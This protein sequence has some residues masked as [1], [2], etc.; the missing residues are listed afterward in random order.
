MKTRMSARHARAGRTPLA[1]KRTPPKQ[2]PSRIVREAL[3]DRILNPSLKSVTALIGP[4]GHG[5]TSLLVQLEER[6]R[7]DGMH[8]AW[9]SLE[10]IDNDLTQLL[11]QFQE[12]LA[13][14]ESDAMAQNTLAIPFDEQPST[15]RVDWIMSRLLALTRPVAVF[16]DDLHVIDNDV[17]LQFFRSLVLG[18]EEPVHFFFASRNNL[19]V[20]FTQQAVADRGLI[21]HTDDLLFSRTESRAFLRRASGV[22][23]S[24]DEEE[25]IFGVT[26]GWPAATQL[27]RLVL[28][29]PQGRTL[30]SRGSLGQPRELADYLAEN[31]LSQQSA[32]VQDFLIRSSLLARLSG[33]LCDDVLGRTDSKAMLAALERS[34]LFVHRLE[35]DD[36]WYGYHSLFSTFLQEHISVRRDIDAKCIHARAGEWFRRA[37]LYEPAMHHFC[38]AGDYRRATET[39]GVWLED[40]VPNGKAST[41]ARWA[42]RIPVQELRRDPDVCIKISWGIVFLSAHQH[43]WHGLLDPRPVDGRPH[44]RRRIFECGMSVR[45]DRLREGVAIIDGVDLAALENGRMG[46]FDRSA[47]IGMRGYHAM[48]RGDFAAADAYLAQSY[49]LA[50]MGNSKLLCAYVTAMQAV[51][52]VATAQLPAAHLHVSMLL[53]ATRMEV[54]SSVAEHAVICVLL[55]IMYESN[56]IDGVIAEFER[57]R[58]LILRAAVHDYLIVSFRAAARTYAARNRIEQMLETLRDAESSA[59]KLECPRA[60]ANLRWERVRHELLSGR[61][62]QARTLQSEIVDSVDP[63]PAWVRFSEENEGPVIGRFRFLIHTGLAAVALAEIETHLAIAQ[64]FGR[65]ARQIKLLILASAAACK[66]ADEHRALRALGEA[67]ALA[68]PGCCLRTFLDEGAMAHDLLRHY[69]RHVTERRIQ[70]EPHISLF[71]QRLLHAL[72]RESESASGSPIQPGNAKNPARSP[73]LDAFTQR[74]RRVLSMLCDYKSND[75]IAQAMFVTRDAVKYHLKNIYEKL[76]VHSRLEAIRVAR[77]RDSPEEVVNQ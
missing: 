77:H 39:F 56:D 63:D 69:S 10:A 11:H 1:Y 26:R 50:K 34:G 62:E 38:E 40:L 16:F 8:T 5:K 68:A 47:A 13:D 35:S 60:I 33:D 67:L 17:V 58:E 18:L 36:C 25:T 28:L 22:T 6:C 21:V 31:V 66:L 65:V 73:G 37:G 64:Q 51:K 54:G 24:T 15:S 30:L 12:L 14:L 4:A 53:A 48:T 74:E 72:D 76:G 44:D 2:Q 59:L 42:H 41:V 45:R 27:Y 61:I 43:R 29:T 3:L 20:G 49:T 70:V 32:D 55:L 46:F 57:N 75:Q 71:L 23:L 7:A 19:N 9:L 52:L